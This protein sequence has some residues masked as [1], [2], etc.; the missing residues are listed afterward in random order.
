M[1][2]KLYI[3]IERRKEMKCTLPKKSMK[4]L[5]E[6]KSGRDNFIIIVGDFSITLS[7]IN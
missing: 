6:V 7:L 4:K 2:R 1:W 3:V 5:T